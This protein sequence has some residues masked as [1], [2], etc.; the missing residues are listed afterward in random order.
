MNSNKIY[1]ASAGLVGLG[2]FLK[3]GI[4]PAL[5]VLGVLGILLTILV[6]IS[7]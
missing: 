4:A 7:I 5:V 6:Q 3:S 2:V 1:V